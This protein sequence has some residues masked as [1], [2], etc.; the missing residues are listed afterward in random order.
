MPKR[1]VHYEYLAGDRIRSLYQQI[2]RGRLSNIPIQ[3]SPTVPLIGQV[4]IGTP[5][6]KE[7]DL[8]RQLEAVLKHLEKHQPGSIGTVDE[9]RTYIAGTL[10]MFSFFLPLR[11]IQRR[12]PSPE[13]IYY[14]C[15]TNST[16]L[17]LA[18]PVHNLVGKSQASADTDKEPSSALPYL[19]GVLAKEYDTQTRYG[20]PDDEELAL[21]GVE[22]M[23]E[24]NG[25][26][27]QRRAFR[28]LATVKLDS[29]N[30]IGRDDDKRII[31]ASPIYMALAD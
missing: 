7:P 31:L 1:I 24:N 20:I 21:D 25:K 6:N 13:F 9:P 22:A 18:G 5:T 4:S 2:H 3:V 15:S 14:G 19:V 16:I 27:K 29:Q 12:R 8:T 10:R 17:G 26:G 23:E 30:F 28:F 11:Y